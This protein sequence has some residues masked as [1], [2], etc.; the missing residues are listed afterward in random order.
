MKLT[1]NLQKAYQKHLSFYH[2]VPRTSFLNENS[3]KCHPSYQMVNYLT[4]VRKLLPNIVS[5]IEF[6]PMRIRKIKGPQTEIKM[7]SEQESN[8]F[9]FRHQEALSVKNSRGQIF[10]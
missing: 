3:N 6:K 9:S 10:R 7:N 4:V 8:T 1:F 2:F 5:T